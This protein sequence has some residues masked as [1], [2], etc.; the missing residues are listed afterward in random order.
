MSARRRWNRNRV[1]ATSLVGLLLA[2]APGC[3]VNRRMVRMQT[4]VQL[5]NDDLAVRQRQ[6]HRELGIMTQLAQHNA[7]TLSAVNRQVEKM[8]RQVATS[9]AEEKLAQQVRQLEHLRR[10]TQEMNSTMA[11]ME[12]R[13]AQMKDLQYG[14]LRPAV[15]SPQTDAD[16]A[17]AETEEPEVTGS[18]IQRG[19]GLISE[20]MA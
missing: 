11:Q 19:D 15:P 3:S 5:L 1:L 9:G 14:M 16:L 10:T 18:H 8:Q 17:T 6:I 2:L 12:A 7:A 13:A 4:Q 20:K